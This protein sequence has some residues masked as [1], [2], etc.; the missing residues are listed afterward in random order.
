MRN[1]WG[2]MVELSWTYWIYQICFKAIQ[3]FIPAIPSGIWHLCRPHF[4]ISKAAQASVQ[5]PCSAVPELLEALRL[6]G[7]VG[8]RP[9]E[10]SKSVNDSDNM[11]CIV[12]TCY[13]FVLPL[14]IPNTAS[15]RY[16]IPIMQY[17]I[18]IH[19]HGRYLYAK[20]SC[21]RVRFS[22]A[23]KKSKGFAKTMV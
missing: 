4:L 11:K 21:T 16:G 8:G 5:S 6:R 10:M 15:S 18:D 22:L 2:V 20:V 12:M 3:A 7:P 13:D 19:W 9:Q 1:K 14:Y 23:S 17:D